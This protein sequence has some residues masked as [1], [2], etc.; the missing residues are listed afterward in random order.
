M[1]IEISLLDFV[2]RVF[3]MCCLIG[4]IILTLW[5]IR[6]T[7]RFYEKCKREF[8]EAHNDR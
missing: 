2:I 4:A 7:K 8:E 6:S 3:S 1:T 5:D